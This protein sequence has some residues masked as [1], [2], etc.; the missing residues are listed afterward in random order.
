MNDTKYFVRLRIGHKSEMLD[1]PTPNGLTHRWTVFVHSFSSIPFTDRSFISKVVFELHP[2]FP[3]PRRVI[4]EPPFE[5]TEMGYAGFS[6]P[7]HITFTG[8]SKNYKLTY[9]MNLVLGEFLFSFLLTF[10]YAVDSLA[11]P[12]SSN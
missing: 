9:D 4:K 3:N 6:I 10:I 7:I 11:L 2:D 12:A 8:A 1:R 5:V